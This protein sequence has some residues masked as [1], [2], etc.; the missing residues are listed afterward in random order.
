MAT[1]LQTTISNSFFFL[2]TCWILVFGHGGHRDGRM[3]GTDME[4]YSVMSWQQVRQDGHISPDQWLHY[5]LMYYTGLYYTAMID[6]HNS[7]RP[8]DTYMYQ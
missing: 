8:S 4:K 2:E 5:G 1:I 6:P 7:W 3:T